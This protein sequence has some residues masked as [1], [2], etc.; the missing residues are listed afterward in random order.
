ML[1]ERED[2]TSTVNVGMRM[3]AIQALSMPVIS[4]HHASTK[5]MGTL[6]NARLA[7]STLALLMSQEPAARIAMNVSY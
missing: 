3:S 7:G 5:T 1:P 6:V 4:M 2:S